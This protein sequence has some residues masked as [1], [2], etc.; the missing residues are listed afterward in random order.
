MDQ[1]YLIT[2]TGITL[3]SSVRNLSAKDYRIKIVE[4][5]CPFMSMYPQQFL[6][7]LTSP[8]S[9]YSFLWK[10][11]KPS[12]RKRKNKKLLRNILQ[13]LLKSSKQFAIGGIK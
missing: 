8:N 13:I 5:R 6:Q 2:L 4:D 1:L 12:I 10:I 11:D 7:S 9:I 3:P